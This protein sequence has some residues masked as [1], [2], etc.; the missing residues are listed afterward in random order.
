MMM[1]MI[2]LGTRKSLGLLVKEYNQLVTCLYPSLIEWA[3]ISLGVSNDGYERRLLLLMIANS[4]H[5][6]QL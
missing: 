4:L 1:L 2:C 5:R 6:F 3:C